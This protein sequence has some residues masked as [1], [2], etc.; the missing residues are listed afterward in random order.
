MS[1]FVYSDNNA[2]EDTIETAFAQ[3]NETCYS[4]VN[5]DYHADSS[6][7]Y[8]IWRESAIRELNEWTA[9]CPNPDKCYMRDIEDR[10]PMRVA[11]NSVFIV[12][13]GDVRR[14]FPQLFR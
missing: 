14:I 8:Y 11:K 5:I 6:S 7:T 4:G 1:S 10:L 12:S 2:I 3:T 13:K 9:N